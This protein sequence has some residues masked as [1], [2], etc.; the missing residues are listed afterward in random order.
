MDI[1]EGYFYHISDKFFLEVNEPSLMANK[2]DGNYRP[3]YLAIRDTLNTEIFWMIPV[4]SKYTKFAALY[5]KQ[6]KK[7]GLCTKI[8][9]G[10]CDGKDAAYLIQNAFPVTADFFDHIHIS[11]G[12][13]LTV[14]EGTGKTIVKNL[15]NNL[16]LQKK[17]INL[18]FSDIGRIYQLMLKHLEDK[19]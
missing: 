8:V 16:R 6:I 9:L 14:H 18:F 2:E 7:Y 11:N 12:V 4:S 1:I 13:P 3:H 17:G 5:D 19:K 15:K 10:K